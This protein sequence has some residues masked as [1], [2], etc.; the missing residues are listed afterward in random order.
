MSNFRLKQ[1]YGIIKNLHPIKR[2][3]RLLF[4]SL[5]KEEGNFQWALLF[6]FEKS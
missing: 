1:E 5:E 2:F 3:A 4:N 6:L